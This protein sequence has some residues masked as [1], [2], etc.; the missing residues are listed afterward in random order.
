MDSF[1]LLGA[2][3][4]CGKSGAY[5]YADDWHDCVW[6]RVCDWE[7]S[8]H[9]SIVVPYYRGVACFRRGHRRHGWDCEGFGGFFKHP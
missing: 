5:S 1:P 3:G 6:A 8:S 9:R 4:D 7:K 2:V